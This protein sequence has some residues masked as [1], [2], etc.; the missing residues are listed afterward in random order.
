MEDI[1]RAVVK[2]RPRFIYRG[3]SEL[4]VVFSMLAACGG[5]AN[6]WAGR[7]HEVLVWLFDGEDDMDGWMEMGRVRDLR[8]E[9]CGCWVVT[10]SGE[11]R[12]Y[13]ADA[14]QSKEGVWCYI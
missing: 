2:M 8:Q 5:L 6:G 14:L 10:R 12:N 11:G 7:M 3:S 4:R 1:C 9:G 13:Q